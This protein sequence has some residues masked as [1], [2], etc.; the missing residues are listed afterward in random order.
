MS[1]FFFRFVGFVVWDGVFEKLVD[2]LIIHWSPTLIATVHLWMDVAS[3]RDPMFVRDKKFVAMG[4]IS[5][6][7]V[8][9]CF[10]KGS[11]G[12]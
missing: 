9:N 12:S 7:G 6:E 3:D 11:E 8:E 10:V 5:P 1:E 4:I 2:L